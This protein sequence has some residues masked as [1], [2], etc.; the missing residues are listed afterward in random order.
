MKIL[1]KIMAGIIAS[2]TCLG[3]VTSSVS[4]VASSYKIGDVDGDGS[5][6]LSDLS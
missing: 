4:A 1:K 5:V 3:M 6:T 2:M